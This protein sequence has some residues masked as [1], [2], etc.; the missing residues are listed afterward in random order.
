[1]KALRERIEEAK[2]II[3]G[4]EPDPARVIL[5]RQPYKRGATT[6]L[7][8]FRVGETRKYEGEYIYSTLKSVA[9]K[10]KYDYGCMYCF[11]S[12]PE[13]KFITRIR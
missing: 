2:R 6:Y 8:S 13:G 4:K 7:A 11:N 1:M 9:S 5:K 10:L 3:R 12:S